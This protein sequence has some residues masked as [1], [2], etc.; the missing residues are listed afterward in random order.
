MF[1]GIEQERHIVWSFEQM[2]DGS[3]IEDAG[4][5]AQAASCQLAWDPW[6]ISYR[7]SYDDSLTGRIPV[8]QRQNLVECFVSESDSR[9]ALQVGA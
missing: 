7:S 5:L 3:R 2:Q 1:S 8:D 9:R 4:E 6:V